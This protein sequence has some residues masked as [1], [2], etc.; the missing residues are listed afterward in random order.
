MS[1][2]SRKAEKKQTADR[3]SAAG[4]THTNTWLLKFCLCESSWRRSSGEKRQAEAKISK[5]K[6]DPQNS[7]TAE[8]RG[9][10]KDKRKETWRSAESSQQEK[11]K[12][13]VF[14]NQMEE[15]QTKSASRLSCSLCRNPL[16]SHV[17][18]AY[19]YLLKVNF[20]EKLQASSHENKAHKKEKSVCISKQKWASTMEV[21]TETT[22]VW[23]W[24]PDVES[25]SRVF[26][27]M[28][29]NTSHVSH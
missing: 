16:A 17:P 2:S 8:R 18:K 25:K 1:V 13:G 6:T 11:R 7:E 14:P 27:S 3:V 23:I 12:A 22:T 9:G 24:T 15:F 10:I 28:L 5:R 29:V 19:I 26:D 4:F 21:G 20:L